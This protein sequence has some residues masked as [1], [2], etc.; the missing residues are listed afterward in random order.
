MR[1]CIWWAASRNFP[2]A[3]GLASSRKP[4]LASSGPRPPRQPVSTPQPLR[5]PRTATGHKAQGAQG[6]GHRQG[7]GPVAQRAALAPTTNRDGNRGAD[8]LTRGMGTRH[9]GRYT[10]SK[11]VGTQHPPWPVARQHTSGP[12][13]GGA[14][15]GAWVPL[16]VLA[17]QLVPGL[18]RERVPQLQR[19][20]PPCRKDKAQPDRRLRRPL[21]LRICHTSDPYR[22]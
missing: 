13:A 21:E 14:P 4:T 18:E 11:G 5:C 16:L 1:R 10:A 6:T 15:G 12:D 22:L 9:S 2:R 8:I 7:T 17:D 3:I 20:R 19:G